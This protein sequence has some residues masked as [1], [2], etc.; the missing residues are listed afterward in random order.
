MTAD[1]TSPFLYEIPLLPNFNADEETAIRLDSGP[2]LPNRN[3]RR[4]DRL[5]GSFRKRNLSVA[6]RRGFVR[7]DLIPHR[8]TGRSDFGPK[9]MPAKCS[10]MVL[11]SGCHPFESGRA[12]HLFKHLQASTLRLFKRL[13]FVRIDGTLPFDPIQRGLCKEPLNQCPL[14]KSGHGYKF[15]SKEGL[16]HFTKLL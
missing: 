10:G 14:K 13:S 4:R 9:Q 1:R 12:H 5:L 8:H 11:E 7:C 15:S 3:L 6:R 16:L 2:R